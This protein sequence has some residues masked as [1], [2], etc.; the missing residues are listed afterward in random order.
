MLLR[1]IL[2]LP[3]G[4]ASC[5]ISNVFDGRGRGEIFGLGVRFLPSCWNMCGLIP[6]KRHALLPG[7]LWQSPGIDDHIW[8]WV[9]FKICSSLCDAKQP[10]LEDCG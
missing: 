2:R 6:E 1:R 4:K 3:R 9:H 7:P 10:M 5:L 8:W